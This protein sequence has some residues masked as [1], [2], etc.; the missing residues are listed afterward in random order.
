MYLRKKACPPGSGTS[1]GLATSIGVE[2]TMAPRTALLLEPGFPSANCATASAS[3]A[4][5]P[6][7]RLASAALLVMAPVNESTWTLTM[8]VPSQV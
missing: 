2:F 8:L 6:M 7:P 5:A 4:V 1:P 3:S